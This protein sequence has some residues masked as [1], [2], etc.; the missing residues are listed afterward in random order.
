MA[1]FA[2][3]IF[4]RTREK[5]R[6]PQEVKFG[7]GLRMV[8]SIHSP[9][10]SIRLYRNRELLED[11]RSFAPAGTIIKVDP[12]GRWAADIGGHTSKPVLT[13]G[14]FN[15]VDAVLDFLHECGHLQDPVSTDLALT[16]EN[17]YT[18]Q[19]FKEKSNNKNPER[20]RAL[21]TR[22]EAKLKSE[23]NAWAFAIRIA[24]QLDQRYKRYGSDI[25]KRM[26][27]VDEVL[28]Y[29][30]GYVGRYEQ[31]TITELEYLG[32]DVYSKTQM[33]ELLLAKMNQ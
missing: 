4:E 7:N 23:R 8:A 21:H 6:G 25:I 31:Q 29:V 11:L 13:M 2:P 14:K 24:R 30:N 32:F 19:F 9:K 33:E 1:E 3:G 22:N 17:Q 5:I 20:F 10:P 16:A 27:G 15:G 18:Q 26:G 12:K 28:K